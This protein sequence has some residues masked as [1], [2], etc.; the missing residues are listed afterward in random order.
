MFD[1]DEDRPISIIISTLA[2]TAYQGQRTIADTLAWVLPRMGELF[3]NRGGLPWVANPSYPLENFA[4]KWAEKPRKQQLFAAWLQQAN[5]DCGEYL[6]A[7][8]FNDIPAGLATRMVVAASPKSPRTRALARSK[9]TRL[10]TSSGRNTGSANVTEWCRP[11]GSARRGSGR[12]NCRP[13][14]STRIPLEGSGL[15]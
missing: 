2:A 5:K 13:T 1:G 7:S 9:R 10:S 6:R 8:R 14:T 15:R 11:P 4:E 3:E 12:R